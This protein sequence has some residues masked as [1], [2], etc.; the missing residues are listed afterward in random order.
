M[1]GDVGGRGGVT[2][3]TGRGTCGRIFGGAGSGVGGK[4]RHARLAHAH[5]ATRPGT[6]RFD[7]F[8]RSVVTRVLRLE[9]RKNALGAVGGPEGE[10]SVVLLVD[11]LRHRGG[12]QFGRT[13][14]HPYT[15]STSLMVPAFKSVQ[16]CPYSVT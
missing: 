7:G 14:G 15:M 9:A 16:T 11:R 2:G 1:T 3:G 5:L 13:S 8:A 10:R 12:P 6:R 4:R